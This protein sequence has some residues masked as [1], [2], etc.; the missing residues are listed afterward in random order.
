MSGIIA[1]LYWKRYGAERKLR[2]S[3][4]RVSRSKNGETAKVAFYEV[5]LMVLSMKDYVVY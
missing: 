3:K 5:E 4:R 1:E 2:Q